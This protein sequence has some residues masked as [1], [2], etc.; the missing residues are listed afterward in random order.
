MRPTRSPSEPSWRGGIH[1][2]VFFRVFWAVA[3]LSLE[4]KFPVLQ[5]AWVPF[6]PT[7]SPSEPSWRGELHFTVFQSVLRT[8]A[9][10]SRE[11]MSPVLQRSWTPLR[12]T[13]KRA[14]L[15]GRSFRPM[16]QVLP[17]YID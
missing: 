11:G 16:R 17:A 1:F 4:G 3:R 5:R 8:F 13:R 15:R 14:R 10:L 12:S 7:R 9:R 2:L 6:R